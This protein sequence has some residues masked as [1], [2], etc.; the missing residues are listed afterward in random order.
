[1]TRRIIMVEDGQRLVAEATPRLIVGGYTPFNTKLEETNTI[2]YWK[3]VNPTKDDLVVMD[4]N[5]K[6]AGVNFSGLTVLN[7]LN[8][9]KQK[10]QIPGLEQV[11]VATSLK[12][13]LDSPDICL[14]LTAY[15]VY[16][17]E[18]VWVEKSLKQQLNSPDICLDLTAYRVYGLEKA[19]GPNNQVVSGSYA[20]SLVDTIDKVYAG[21]ARQ[22]NR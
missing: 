5:F 1:M 10:G 8:R 12:R 16:G 17:L 3:K 13:Q 19:V 7:L 2:E 14:D 9:E 6:L 11:L 21:T 22:L 4:L 18:K 15:R 20:N